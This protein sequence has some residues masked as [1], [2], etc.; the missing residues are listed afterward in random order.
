MRSRRST[1][2]MLCTREA[3]PIQRSDDGFGDGGADA[4]WHRAAGARPSSLS[5]TARSHA[6][7]Q[8]MSIGLGRRRAWRGPDGWR[9]PLDRGLAAR[10]RWMIRLPDAVTSP[11]FEV[12]VVQRASSSVLNPSWKEGASAQVGPASTGDAAST[13]RGCASI[14]SKP[15]NPDWHV[16]RAGQSASGCT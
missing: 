13:G 8:A 11:A 3:T 10:P 6:A 15:Q 16:N 9:A 1:Q 7:A 12:S 2:P 5:G 14:V 4:C